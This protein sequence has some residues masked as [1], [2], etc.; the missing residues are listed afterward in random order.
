[1]LPCTALFPEVNNSLINAWGFSLFVFENIYY[2]IFLHTL[3]QHDFPSCHT[4]QGSCQDFFFFFCF[5]TWKFPSCCP[6]VLMLQFALVVLLTSDSAVILEVSFVVI[7][8]IPFTSLLY[9]IF[10][11]WDS[12]SSFLI[13]SPTLAGVHPP[14]AA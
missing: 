9:W 12:L 7:L 5:L 1:M 11:F 8:E 10:V 4:T 13:C 6:F 14:V 3:L 2:S